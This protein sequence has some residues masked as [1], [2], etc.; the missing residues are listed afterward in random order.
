MDTCMNVLYRSDIFL[1]STALIVVILLVWAQ[2]QAS[3]A[4][5]GSNKADEDKFT[6][7]LGSAWIYLAILFALVAFALVAVQELYKCAIGFLGLSFLMMAASVGLAFVRT[8]LKLI[9]NL[10]GDESLYNLLFNEGKGR[11][12]WLQISAML[13][14]VLGALGLSFVSFSVAGVLGSPCSWSNIFLRAG[15]VLFLVAGVSACVIMF[16]GARKVRRND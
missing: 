8:L 16:K 14:A 13:I 15:V 10:P 12:K 3:G 9:F 1:P 11:G 4:R 2:L 7:H 6:L 5:V